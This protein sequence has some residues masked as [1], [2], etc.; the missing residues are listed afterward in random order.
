MKGLKLLGPALIVVG[1]VI[2]ARQ[3]VDLEMLKMSEVVNESN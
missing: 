3:I 1:E 2:N